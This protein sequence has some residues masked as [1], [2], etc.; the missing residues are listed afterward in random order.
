M[1]RP[2]GPDA[3]PL[4]TVAECAELVGRS[5]R[6]IQRWLEREGV[7]VEYH[8]VSTRAGNAVRTAFVDPA[9]LPCKLPKHYLIRKEASQEAP[10][11]PGA[12]L[13]LRVAEAPTLEAALAVAQELPLGERKPLL[14]LVSGR[15]DVS[16]RTLY[17][18]L[19]RAERGGLTLARA[20]AG[21]PRI[22]QLA[23]EL[24]VR[25][26]VTNPPTT[27]ARMIHRTLMRAAP[28]AMTYMRGGEKQVVS[29]RTVHRIRQELLEDPRTR[30][31]FSDTDAR[32][33]YLRVY[34]G[35]VLPKHA[36]DLWQ[37]DMTRCDVVVVEPQTGWIGRPRVH[38]II[39]VYS[40]VIPGITFS[41]AEDQ[42]QTD[43]TLMRA[44]LPKRGPLADLYV[45]RGKPNALH[46]DNGP[47]YVSHQMN[48]VTGGLTIKL[49]HSRPY[50]SHTRGSIE[51]FF[52]TLHNFERALTGYVGENAVKRSSKEIKRLEK[53][54][55]EWLKHG[56]DPGRGNRLLT[57]NEYQEAVLAWLI[58]EYHQWVVDGL[59]RHEHFVQTAPPSTLVE[60]DEQE[61]LLL[62]AHREERV[63]DATGRF[64]L[65]N[66]WWAIPDGSLAPYQHTKVLVLTDQ[67]ALEP[68]KKLVAWVDR[69]GQ[70]HV[71]GVAEPAPEVAASIEAHDLRRASR[72]AVVEEARRQREAKREL[73]DPNLRVDTVLIKELRAAAGQEQLPAP[74]RA[75]LEAVNP[76]E[77]AIE[78]E[79]NDVIG[80]HLLK[81]RERTGAPKDPV[82]LARWI[83]ARHG[84]GTGSK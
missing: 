14:E 64:R 8:F 48:R 25:A 61:L 54:T 73:T 56:R 15:F 2:V 76:P 43:L 49:I 46:T 51:R 5:P 13:E 18:R 69:R 22:P 63:V 4:L 77:E 24:I 79:P 20:D 26:L 47:G 82:E 52:G 42:A 60:L 81:Q 37:L 23:R 19:A 59:T 66:R 3:Q 58:G 1:V 41:K 9:T 35:A 28:E 67:F 30:L 55:R 74:A 36:N 31:W 12:E 21:R 62:F 83:A 34:S 7:Y 44:L 65:G 71:I 84:K 70:H 33:E 45:Y 75:R 40:G 39:D 72:I 53:N 32:E 29:V 27:S 10:A 80:Q 57:I 50:T 16:L 17:R 78:F 11:A 68:D 6:T 38:A